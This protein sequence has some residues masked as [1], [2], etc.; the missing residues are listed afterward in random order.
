MRDL[1]GSGM[2][3]S[4]MRHR[5]A[6]VILP[7]TAVAVLGMTDAAS[8]ELVGLADVQTQSF[9]FPL[10]PGA[11]VLSFDQFDDQGGTRL[12]D[13]VTLEVDGMIGALVTAENDS[14]LPAPDF[15]VS[16][17]GFM[18]VDFATL[19]TNFGF[20]ETF[21]TDGSVTPTDGVEG[22][23]TDFWDFGLVAADASDQDS[24]TSGLAGFVGLG[25]LDATVSAAGGFSV[26]GSTDSTLV[27]SNFGGAGEVTV[28]YEYTL[29]PAPGA[30]ALMG[31]AGLVSRT[32]RRR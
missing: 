29:V 6:F 12:L 3:R 1:A 14:V 31:L 4:M 23:G 7:L 21:L 13:R 30:M 26:V 5:T 16:I 25:T 28:V 9:A 22:S 18:N 24:T 15:G 19:G 27:I 10:S 32:R 2:W 20:D 8:A 11:Q 17:A